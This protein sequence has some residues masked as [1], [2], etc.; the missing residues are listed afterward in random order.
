[1]AT[2]K[3]RAWTTASGER[4]EAWRVRY[5]DQHGAARTR[6]FD[7]RRDADAFRIKAESEILAGRHTADRAS[8]SVAEAADLWIATAENNGRERGTI[9]SYREIADLHIKP[10]LGKEK[11]SRLTMPKVE[12]FADSLRSTRSTAMAGKAVRALS[13]IVTE[14]M[15]RGLVSQNVVR[16]VT[17][18]RSSRDKKRVVIPPIEHLKALIAAADRLG[19][20]DPRMPV[21]LRLAML[22][23]L[24]SSELRGLGW[25]N[26]DLVKGALSV[27]QRADRW[28]SIG[29]PKSEAGSRAI[30][31]GPALV[32][33]LRAWKLQCPPSPLD[34]V[35]PNRRGHP[36]TQHNI[37][38][39][40][41]ALQIEAG[42]AIA[43]GKRDEEG[44]MILA[45]RYG[46]HSIRHA[47]A[48]S[49]IKQGID[50]KRLQVWIGHANIQLT[51]DTYGHLITDAQ[52]D[53]TLAGGSEAALFAS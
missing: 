40:F 32:S 26:I 25:P 20:D 10:L 34:L 19:A 35:F 52:A 2:V 36:M 47:A 45:P 15:R 7:L 28:N 18:R 50:L 30:P 16:G 13:M 23:G 44:N 5:V 43:S 31:I 46:L 49:W 48:S 11:L 4:R 24:R 1:M 42:L 51:L 39:R 37:I 53:A 29:D 12:A 3:K 33:M 38:A 17:V 9:K 8:V 21:L 14:A 6:Q 22:T 27:T 41:L